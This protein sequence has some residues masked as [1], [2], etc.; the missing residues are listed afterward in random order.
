M[1]SIAL[2]ILVAAVG[3]S[4]LSFVWYMA[5]GSRLATLSPAYAA[6]AEAPSPVVPALELGRSLVA[7]AVLAALAHYTNATT[8][9]GGVALGLIAW[10]GFPFV[11]LSGSVLHENYPWKL[12]AI[13]LGDWLLKLVLIS[14]IVAAW[15]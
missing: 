5:F 8:L 12:A 10:L 13:H 6:G 4:L 11:I 2:S 1:T 7:A 14:G 15:R 9:L 3:A